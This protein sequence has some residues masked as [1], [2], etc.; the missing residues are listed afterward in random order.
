MVE[1]IQRLYRP[2]VKSVKVREPRETK[3]R[4]IVGAARACFSGANYG[5]EG[6]NITESMIT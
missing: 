3:A 1:R 4:S 6:R 2:E 5:R